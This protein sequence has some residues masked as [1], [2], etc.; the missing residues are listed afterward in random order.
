MFGGS[1][2]GYE[3]RIFIVDKSEIKDGDGLKYASH[4][5]TFDMGKCPEIAELFRNAPQ[6]DCYIFASD[7]NTRIVKDNYNEPLTEANIDDVIA[8]LE[9]SVCEDNCYRRVFPLL[10][11]LRAIKFQ[12]ENSRAWQNVVVL[13]YGY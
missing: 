5:V 3:S 6:T 11:T 2:M 12:I 1:D 8:V 9:K 13:H 7:G 10:A 4:I